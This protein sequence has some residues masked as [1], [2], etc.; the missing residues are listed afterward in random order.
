MDSRW[1]VRLHADPDAHTNT[2]AYANTD[3][4]PYAN[5]YTELRFQPVSG[6]DQRRQL[7]HRRDP[8]H[9]DGHIRIGDAGHAVA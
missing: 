9:G 4:H 7:E 1:F 8:D 3:A 5:A 2:N 6:R